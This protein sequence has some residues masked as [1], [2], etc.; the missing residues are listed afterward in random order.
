ML[1]TGQADELVIGAGLDHLDVQ[2]GDVVAADHAVLAAMLDQHARLDA[3]GGGAS[4]G[5]QRAVEA[6]HAVQRHALA[7]HIQHHLAAEAVAHRAQFGGIGL[8][9][10]L[11][12]V[13]A[14]IE[15]ALGSIG[16]LQG[17]LHEAHGV[18]RMIG[19]LAFAVHVDGEGTVAQSGEVAGA[20]LGVVV[21][22]PPFVY[23]DDA[24]TLAFDGVVIGVV[25]DHLGAIGSGVGNFLRLNLGIRSDAGNHEQAEQAVAHL[26]ISLMSLCGEGRRRI[27][28]LRLRAQRLGSSDRAKVRI[29]RKSPAGWQGLFVERGRGVIRPGRRHVP[30]DRSAGRDRCPA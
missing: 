30:L 11:E 3:A 7:G 22:P 6:D 8:C 20:L 12:Q 18:F 16:V 23:H 26:E 24:G 29:K 9:L 17:C 25:A 10:F 14:G 15:A 1:G 19:V 4:F 27:A 5:G 28:V 2:C 13:E 21:Q